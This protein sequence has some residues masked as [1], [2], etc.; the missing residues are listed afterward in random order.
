MANNLPPGTPIGSGLR[1]GVIRSDG[2]GGSSETFYSNPRDIL[3][4]SGRTR[5]QLGAPPTTYTSELL[6]G[7]RIVSALNITSSSSTTA[8]TINFLNNGASTA[9]I[10]VGLYANS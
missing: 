1:G 4:T 9:N 8:T 10:W 2:S 7:Q 3:R 6:P 5:T